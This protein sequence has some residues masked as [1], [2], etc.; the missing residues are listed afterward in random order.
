VAPLERLKILMQVQGNQKVYQNTWQVRLLPGAAGLDVHALG[1]QGCP[2]LDER[3][4][5]P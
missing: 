3:S 1:Q 4:R 2:C 5:S